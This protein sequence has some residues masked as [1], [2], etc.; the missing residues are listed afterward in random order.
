MKFVKRKSLL[1]KIFLTTS[2]VSL[3]G[4]VGAPKIT[5]H[6]IDTQL[7]ECREYEVTNKEQM[8]IR[9]KEAHP[10]SHCNGFFAVPAS[11]AAR[12]RKYCLD[13]K[14]TTPK[15]PVKVIE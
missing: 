10:L 15:P 8:T 4:C 3:F 7:N 2:L 11:E 12:W 5:P 13:S 9:F 1:K 6:Y 14:C